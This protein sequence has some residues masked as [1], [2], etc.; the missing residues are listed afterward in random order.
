V[1][2][3]IV[4]AMVAIGGIIALAVATSVSAAQREG[5]NGGAAVPPD[6]NHIAA[7]LLYNLLV[8]GG[9]PRGGALKAIRGIG[10]IAPVVSSI[11]VRNWAERFAQVAPPDH[12]ASLLEAAVK[13]VA[14]RTSPVPLRQYNALLDLS[15]GLGFQTDALA[16]LRAKYNFDYI[17]HAK[18]A[19]PREAD[20]AGGATPLFAR[21]QR[22]DRELL[23]VLE[24]EGPATRDVIIAAYRRLA[25]Q[26]HPD[27]V[28]AEPAEVQ[29]AAA[30]RFIEITSAYQTLLV[31]YPE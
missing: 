7:S 13:L 5:S 1:E 14:E 11:D 31:L 16:K 17:D 3:V 8:A 6:R 12:C 20:R 4:L 2:V 19:R 28:Y 15:F 25:A 18:D 10:L 21:Q 27:R 9:T 23:R 29:S 30:A 22:D 26:H 24:I